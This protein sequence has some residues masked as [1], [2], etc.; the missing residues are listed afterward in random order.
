ML[1]SRGFYLLIVEQVASQPSLSV[2]RKWDLNQG[3]VMEKPLTSVCLLPN[4]S[5]LAFFKL[6]ALRW[7]RSRN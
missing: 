3:S 6:I 4:H 1:V 7:S 5:L 2:F